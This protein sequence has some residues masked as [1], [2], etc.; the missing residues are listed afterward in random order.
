MSSDLRPPPHPPARGTTDD[1]PDDERPIRIRLDQVLREREMTMTELSART[2]I[3]MANLSVLKTNKA[4]AIRMSTLAS[5][6]R[7]LHITPGDLLA[8]NS[9]D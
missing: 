7:A 4:K 2:G 3:T 1:G 8:L 6:C 9:T 5:I